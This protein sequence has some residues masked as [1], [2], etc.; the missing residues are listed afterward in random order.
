VCVLHRQLAGIDAV[1]SM[2]MYLLRCQ[3]V[4]DYGAHTYKVYKN[5]KKYDEGVSKLLIGPKGLVC[6]DMKRKKSKN[7]KKIVLWTSLKHLVLKGRKLKLL[8][9]SEENLKLYLKNSVKAKYIHQ[10][11]IESYNFYS[12]AKPCSKFSTL[13]L[14]D[15]ITKLSSPMEGIYPAESSLETNVIPSETSAKAGNET[16]IT[17]TKNKEEASKEVNSIENSFTTYK[18]NFYSRKVQEKNSLPNLAKS[19][20]DISTS[21]EAE[22]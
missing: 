19:S 21:T 4:E 17:N 1:Q 6:S 22:C 20:E 16:E 15:G 7:N 8:Q 13:A 12:S 2:R 5:K 9:K 3:Q 10:L 11:V 18:N 14:F